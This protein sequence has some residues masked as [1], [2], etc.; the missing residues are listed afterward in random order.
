MTSFSLSPAPP[1]RRTPSPPI[2][3]PC[4]PWFIFRLYRTTVT[5]HAADR[6]LRVFTLFTL[7]SHT[8]TSKPCFA[9]PI[10]V[11]LPNQDTHIFLGPLKFTI[12][13][14]KPMGAT[15]YL[16]TN[17]LLRPNYLISRVLKFYFSHEKAPTSRSSIFTSTARCQL[18]RSGLPKAESRKGKSHATTYLL[19]IRTRYTTNNNNNTKSNNNDNNWRRRRI[20]LADR[21]TDDTR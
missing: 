19:P 14:R 1:N 10:L 20:Q 4:Y 7:F 6:S 13:Y 18:P 5:I 12:S 9:Q 3:G 11:E 21:N 16:I 17:P 2:L 8:D 15:L